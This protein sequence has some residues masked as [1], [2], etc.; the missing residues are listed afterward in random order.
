MSEEPKGVRALPPALTLAFVVWLVMMVVR[1][2][3]LLST[4][5]PWGAIRFNLVNEGTGLAAAVLAM[6]GAFEL[7]GRL[8]G[9]EALGT[10]IAAIGFAA[11]LAIDVSYGGLNFLDKAWEHEWVYKTFDYAFFTSWLAVPIGLA[12]ANWRGKRELAIFAVLVSLLTWPPPF[13]AK[14]MYSWLPDGTT[15]WT[16]EVALRA[17]RIAVLFAAFAAIARPSASGDRSLAASGLR[18]AAKALWLRVIAAVAVVLLTLMVIGGKGSK[19]SLDILKLAMLAG[20]VI[21]I[22]A[23][24]QFGVGAAR[25]ARAGVADLARWPILVGASA[26]LWATG[27]TVGQFPWLYKMLYK[28]GESGFMGRDAQE[29]AQALA[30][31][32]PVVVTVGVALVAI[33]INGFAAKRGNDDLRGHAQA[34]T[35]GFVALTLVGLAIQLWMLPKASSLGSFAMLSLLA[36]G[37]ALVGTVMMA[38]LLGLAAD[39]L[40][41]EPGLPTASVISDGT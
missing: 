34:K 30:V 33:A 31:A 38:K 29:M 28:N 22:I 8:T 25:A 24:A 32:M 40:E 2:V 18:T 17:V 35:A 21:N 26:S 5:E 14:A 3:Y 41:S 16:I 9:R 36:A 19:G 4:K 23:L 11:S 27:V 12:I 1:F 39:A 7:A 6:L 20:G 13:L 10:K 15:G 37:S